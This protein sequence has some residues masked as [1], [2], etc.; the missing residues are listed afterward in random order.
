MSDSMAET[1][2]TM[3][4]DTTKLDDPTTVPVLEANHRNHAASGDV[5]IDM[6]EPTERKDS[7]AK[8]TDT[9]GPSTP[10]RQES[11]KRHH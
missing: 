7:G 3:E 10:R 1:P 9:D 8:V 11:S 2:A 5:D 6:N 4:I